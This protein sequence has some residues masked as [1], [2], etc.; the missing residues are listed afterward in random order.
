MS[1]TP[2]EGSR[3]DLDVATHPPAPGQV[4]DPA[5]VDRVGI[6]AVDVD[7]TVDH[8]QPRV[9]HAVV[10]PDMLGDVVG[11][12]DHPIAPSHDAVVVPLDDVAAVP[13]H[14]VDRGDERHPA[15][16]RGINGA[17]GWRAGMRV[18][19]ADVP[20]ADHALQALDV[21]ADGQRVAAVHRQPQAARPALGELGFAGA[22]VRDHERA[23]AALDQM[24]RQIHGAAFN[25][26]PLELR[27][28][29]QHGRA[30]ADRRARRYPELFVDVVHGQ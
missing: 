27:Q 24:T 3:D 9:R 11:D 13:V 1:P 23:P 16:P 17:P 6:E 19:Q 14:P 5:P 8:A 10:T 29:L 2:R 12:G 15:P 4:L 7:P 26:A 21:G 20:V 22:P 30:G 25:P 18:H 28:D